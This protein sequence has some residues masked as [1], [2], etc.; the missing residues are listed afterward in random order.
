MAT[1]R[2]NFLRNIGFG[3]AGAGGLLIPEAA[4]A[5]L[6]RRRTCP[7]SLQRLPGDIVFVFPVSDP[8]RLVNG[9]FYAWASLAP[10]V[11]ITEFKIVDE[12]NDE[13]TWTTEILNLGTQ[14]WGRKFSGLATGIQFT[15]K[16]TYSKVNDAGVTIPGNTSDH[17][18]FQTVGAR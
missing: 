18:P 12:N 9:I 14:S 10:T 6:F 8:V 11:T 1:S 16:F 15:F 7:Q 5:G 13:L 4:S 3:V 2:R 17:G